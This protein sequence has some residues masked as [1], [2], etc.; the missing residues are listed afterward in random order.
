MLDPSSKKG[1]SS[2]GGTGELSSIWSSAPLNASRESPAEVHDE[3]RAPGLVDPVVQVRYDPLSGLI[4]AATEGGSVWLWTMLMS[5]AEGAVA[6]RVHEATYAGALRAPMHLEFDIEPRTTQYLNVEPMTADAE[7]PPTVNVRILLHNAAESHIHRISV[8]L[9]SSGTLSH[10]ET[11]RLVAPGALPIHTL[12][13]V[14]DNGA[15]AGS[16]I[17]LEKVLVPADFTIK[18]VRPGQSSASAEVSED[19]QGEETTP[20]G[21]ENLDSPSLATRA[22]HTAKDYGQP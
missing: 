16:S 9:R 13:A 4:V 20:T 18:V 15:G 12:D 2:I 22:T 5:R 19:D 3:Q 6:Y 10:V 8:H 17:G 11:S 1:T 21:S 14:L 7:S